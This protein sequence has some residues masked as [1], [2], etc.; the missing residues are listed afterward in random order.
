[1]GRCTRQRNRRQR[2]RRRRV[3]RNRDRRARRRAAGGISS[4][5]RQDDADA[6][7]RLRRVPRACGADHLHDDFA[8]TKLRAFDAV[9]NRLRRLA[10]ALS[11]ELQRAGLN[12]DAPAS[13]LAEHRKPIGRI[14]R[15]P[16]IVIENVDTGQRIRCDRHLIAHQRCYIVLVRTAAEKISHKVLALDERPDSKHQ[17]DA[18]QD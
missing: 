13:G 18:A 5:P 15:K 14:G 11:Q 3:R 9:G 8:L 7:A 16:A 12:E 6:R 17:N 10:I 4:R 1:M 2:T